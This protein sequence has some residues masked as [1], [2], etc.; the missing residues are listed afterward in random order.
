MSGMML[1]FYFR[2]KTTLVTHQCVSCCWAMLYRA[3]DIS[4]FQ[5][6]VLS[7]QWG[8]LRECRAGREQNQ[9]SWTKLSKGIFYTGTAKG[10]AQQKDVT[11]EKE[12]V[13][14]HLWRSRLATETPQGRAFP[15]T[16]SFKWDLRWITLTWVTP[17]SLTIMNEGLEV[18]IYTQ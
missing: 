15:V 14:S 13:H 4:V 10:P 11:E 18:E 6:L 1:C 7:C 5:V 17:S 12:E 8:G 2:R 3:K 16:V 9:N